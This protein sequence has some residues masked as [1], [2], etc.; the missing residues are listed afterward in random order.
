[1]K[2][3]NFPLSV[4]IQ[5]TLFKENITTCALID[6]GSE[7]TILKTFLIKKWEIDNNIRIKGITGQSQAIKNVARDV[8]I[9]LGSKIILIKQVYKYN[10]LEA[11]I[12]LGNDFL[13]QFQFY[14]QNVYMIT[15]KTSCGHLLKI[16]RINRPFRVQPAERG[17][18]Q[19]FEKIP[20]QI[21]TISIKR[22]NFDFVKRKI[23]ENYN[24]NPLAFWKEHH[25]KAKIIL[26]ENVI[27]K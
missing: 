4:F 21:N 26:I 24:D 17:G 14:T 12:L 11:D 3:I 8:E 27:V 23:E 2:G 20:I 19:V 7:I 6:T 25:P 18:R 10:A 5:L 9:I 13:E 15:L 16:P 1:M 22:I